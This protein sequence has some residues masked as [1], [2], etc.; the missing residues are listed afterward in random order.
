MKTANYLKIS[1][2]RPARF[3]G[4]LTLPP[5]KSY[6]HRALFIASLCS[7]SSRIQNSLSSPLSDDVKAS[8]DALESFG[9]RIRRV[10]NSR[11]DL[12]V[13]PHPVSSTKIFAYG[14]GTTARF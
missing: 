2:R 5:S 4:T 14:S 9:S 13:Y 6:F 8:L 1:G 3:Q 12:T 11:E 7:T 10:P